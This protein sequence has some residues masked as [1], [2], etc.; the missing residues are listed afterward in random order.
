MKNNPI[1]HAKAKVPGRVTIVTPS[2]NAAPFIGH[3]IASVRSQTYADIE[4]IVVDGGSTDGTADIS[5]TLA[6]TRQTIVVPG[7]NQA[8]AVNEGFRRSTGEYFTFLNAD[9]TLEPEAISRGVAAL[10]KNPSAAL[11]YAAADHVDADGSTI[12]PYPVGDATLPAL[13]KQCVICQPAVLMRSDAYANSGGLDE[14]LQF[15]MDYDLWLRMVRDGRLL[16]RYDEVWAQS[17]MHKNNKTLG[18]RRAVFHEVF[19]VLRHH[20]GYVP[21]NWVHAYAGF[22]LDGKDHFFDLPTGTPLRTLLTLPLGYFLNPRK[23]LTFTREF[24][25]EMRRIHGVHFA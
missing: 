15:A 14:R 7:L 4:H 10:E 18:R 8:A 24:F 6:G 23:P 16:I 20:L 17:R 21:F 1:L 9:D 13:S 12:G 19:A 3:T 11:A 2:L 5:R 25:A 22:L